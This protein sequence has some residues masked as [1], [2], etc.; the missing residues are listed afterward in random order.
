MCVLL[1][2]FV[3]LRRHRLDALLVIERGQALLEAIPAVSLAS[4][5]ASIELG[6]DLDGSVV[7]VLHAEPDFLVREGLVDLDVL[8]VLVAHDAT[9]LV[10]VQHKLAVLA[11]QAVGD[12]ARDEEREDGPG[13]DQHAVE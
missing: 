5:T 2:L 8:A 9:R 4:Y 1:R 3:L 10:A 11:L 12:A 7:V 6:L 13:K